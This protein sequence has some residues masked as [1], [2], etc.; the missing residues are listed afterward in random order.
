MLSVGFIQISRE[1]GVSFCGISLF[2]YGLWS[3]VIF[4][5][6]SLVLL[7]DGEAGLGFVSCKCSA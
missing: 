1:G 2:C 3:F 7:S 5:V 6:V 4:L